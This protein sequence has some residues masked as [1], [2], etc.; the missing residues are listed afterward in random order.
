MHLVTEGN[1]PSLRPQLGVGWNRAL[2]APFAF[3]NGILPD[4]VNDFLT[5]PKI[6]GTTY[7]NIKTFTL[8]C[9]I[10]PATLLGATNQNILAINLSNGG[11][12]FIEYIS[13][14]GNL[15]RYIAQNGS[16]TL[17]NT[18]AL[19][20]DQVGLHHLVF[21]VDMVNLQ[22]RAFLDGT[23]QGTRTLNAQSV[24]AGNNPTVSSLVLFARAG[25]FWARKI[26]EIRMYNRIIS[27]EEIKANYNQGFGNNPS[28]T[29]GLIFWFD[30]QSAESDSA[31]NPGGNPAGWTSG[32][33]GVRDKTPNGNHAMQSNFSANNSTLG[34][35]ITAF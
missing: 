7:N 35:A 9:W 24:T 6:I 1:S 14:G 4:G 2:P 16:F 10:N 20:G 23:L 31:L 11:Q 26:D 19:I 25:T 8:E 15:F 3:G 12:M 5:I 21:L 28:K 27:I 22:C 34:G 13:S 32:A 33:W 17:D 30:F 18:N 29:E